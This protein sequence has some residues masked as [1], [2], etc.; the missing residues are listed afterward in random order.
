MSLL[1]TRSGR[2]VLYLCA[3]GA[4]AVAFAYARY[5]DR[6]R[7][8]AEV[9]SVTTVTQQLILR[10]PSVTA[11]VVDHRL[12]GQR[13]EIYAAM[14]ASQAVRRSA[15]RRARLPAN[16]P[17]TFGGVSLGRGRTRR[18]RAEAALATIQGVPQ[19]RALV[20]YA[21]QGSVPVIDISVR[22]PDPLLAARLSNAVIDAL[23]AYVSDIPAPPEGSEDRITIDRNGGPLASAAPVPRER[24]WPF[25]GA[26]AFV[27][28]LT[29]GGL[30]H[31]FVRR[32]VRRRHAEA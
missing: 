25:A 6:E 16:Y 5:E 4:L 8:A 11:Q 27:V 19:N 28:L 7:T 3:L 1:R 14:V 12:L 30:L 31:G 26:A 20:S 29:V 9:T 17:V 22:A 15:L 23:I 2:F 32:R 18:Q 24:N 13:G 10:A 21:T